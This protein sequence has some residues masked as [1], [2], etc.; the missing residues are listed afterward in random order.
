MGKNLFLGLFCFFISFVSTSFPSS[1]EP[2]VHFSSEVDL[3]KK[4]IELIENEPKKIRMATERLSDLEVIQA[5]VKA[6]KRGVFVE[7]MVDPITLTRRSPLSLLL[8][9]GVSVFVWKADEEMSKAKKN[10][11]KKRMHHAFGVFGSVTSWV[12]T[13]SFSLKRLFSH[14]E[15]ALVLRDEKV[16]SAYI[17]EFE[18]MKATAAV[19]FLTSI[20]EKKI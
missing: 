16:A 3:S 7:V 6:H 10:E 12:G 14:R 2:L 8:D 13:Y 18:R 17:L 1:V 20:E 19:L 11:S 4:F 9:E 5:L 15:S